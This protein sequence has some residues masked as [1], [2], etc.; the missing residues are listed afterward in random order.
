MEIAVVGSLEFTLGFQLAGV[1]NLHNTSD[2]EP[3]LNILQSIFRAEQCVHMCVWCAN[4]TVGVC[5]VCEK[6]YCITCCM[7][8]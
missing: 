7:D 2:H 5:Y 6:D 4:E 3:S 8:V 1:K